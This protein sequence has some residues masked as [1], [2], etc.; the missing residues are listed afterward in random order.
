MLAMTSDFH[1]ESRKAD[2]IRDCLA[3]IAQA[4]FTHVHWCHEWTG[5][6]IY[7]ASE[8]LQIREWCDEL[9]LLVKGVHATAGEHKSDL[10]LYV[11]ANEYNRLAGVELIRNRLDLAYILDAQAIV[12]HLYLP[13]ERF[14]AEK[15]YRE[16]FYRYVMK[17]F[18]ELEGYCK[19]R[20]IRICIENDN[21]TPAV[22]TY[23]MYDTL[24]IRYSGDYMGLC[25]DTGHAAMI[26]KD[27]CLEYAEH[28]K[29]RLFMIH[30]HDNHGIHDEH[31][32]PFEGCFDWEGFAPVLA[33]S[34]YNMPILM[35]CSLRDEGDDSVWL[36]KAFMAGSRFSAMVQKYKD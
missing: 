32:I 28:Y 5:S 33:R 4:G 20:H 24:F 19:T 2:E 31:L 29:D 10:K 35:E 6:Y 9:G 1:G 15:N 12:L 7:S 14:E 21:E 22:H 8:M 27:N 30:I 17:S 16:Q 26:C 25:F 34:S 18:D 36:E 3:R 13:W 23:Y 11:S